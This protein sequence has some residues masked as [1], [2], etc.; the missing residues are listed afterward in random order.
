MKIML[1]EAALQRRMHARVCAC[2]CVC[3]CVY[4][5]ELHEVS[6]GE[7]V[8]VWTSLP[9]DMAAEKIMSC[10]SALCA[11]NQIINKCLLQN[12]LAFN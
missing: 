8:C 1:H 5:M 10:F 3:V 2:V 9:Q 12:D 11:Q 7:Q 6:I 4:N